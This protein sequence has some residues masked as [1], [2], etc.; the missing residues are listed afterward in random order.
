MGSALKTKAGHLHGE[1]GHRPCCIP[2]LETSGQ[3]AAFELE[4]QFL[5]SFKALFMSWCRNA[6]GFLIF[7]IMDLKVKGF[8]WGVVS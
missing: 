5:N 6:K 3:M 2:V 8:F 1:E 4:K 7:V